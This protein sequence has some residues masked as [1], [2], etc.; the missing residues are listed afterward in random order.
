MKPKATVIGAGLA[1]TLNR[2][3]RIYKAQLAKEAKETLNRLTLDTRVR[4]AD[5]PYRPLAVQV[6]TPGLN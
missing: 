6:A 2:I 4:L 1:N 5:K 3:D